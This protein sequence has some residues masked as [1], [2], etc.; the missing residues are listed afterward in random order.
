MHYR[1]DSLDFQIKLLLFLVSLVA[2]RNLTLL[3]SAATPDQILSI[4]A[5]YI[6]LVVATHDSMV[7]GL[8]GE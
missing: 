1:I 7:R 4:V 5:F 2:K 3:I 8:M 6:V